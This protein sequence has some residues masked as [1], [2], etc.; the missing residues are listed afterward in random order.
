MRAAGTTAVSRRTLLL[1]SNTGVVTRL[2]AFHWATVFATK[3]PPN[4]VIVRSEPF[5]PP[6][7]MVDGEMEVRLAPVFP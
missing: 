5:E 1:A 6:A 3:G 7:L 2:L 4:K